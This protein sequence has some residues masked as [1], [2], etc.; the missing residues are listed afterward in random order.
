MGD[1]GTLNISES[2]GRGGAYPEPSAPSWDKWIN[3]GYLLAPKEEKQENTG[4]VLDVRETLAPPAY[5]L[6][7]QMNVPYHL[8]HLEN[9][10][11]AI[12]GK[13]ELNCPYNVGYET[14]VTVLKVNE[15]VEKKTLLT[16][17]PDEFEI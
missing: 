2:A 9:F 8:P 12:R 4:V 10:F 7:I 15:A 6:P 5:E 16:Y 17:R 1:K 11:N 3:M 13:E 14:A